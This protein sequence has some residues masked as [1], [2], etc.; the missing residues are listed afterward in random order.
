M[1]V[2]TLEKNLTR[3]HQEW[4]SRPDDE[5]YLS[6]DDLY[7]AVCGRANESR[8][9]TVPNR[10]LVVRGSEAAG[11][12]L[13]LEQ[14]DVGI[15]DPTHWSLGQL[16]TLSHTPAKWVREIAGAP[17]GPAFAAHALN[18]GLRHLASPEKV[19]LM[20]RV[21]ETGGQSLRCLV[22]PDYGRIYDY[23]VV[24]AVREMNRD[25]RWRVPAA[26]YSAS[27][28]L[29]A[30]TLY[31]SDR[32]VFIF[33][34]DDRN[35]I[36]FE[37]DGVKRN[38]FRGFMVWNSEVGSHRF[39]LMTFLYNFVCD[40]RIVWGAREVKEIAIRHTR[41]APERFSREALPRLY[42]YAESSVQNVEEQ[43]ARAARKTVTAKDEDVLSWL[44]S[45]DF[46]KKEGESIIE[47]ARSEEGGA[48]TV[49]QLV[50]GGTALARK[51]PHADERVTFERRVSRLLTAAA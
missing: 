21:G 9:L 17:A 48:R 15:L 16:A 26:S 35:P 6:L 36:S 47:M 49:W 22:G 42:A 34:V 2:A 27:N 39:G 38:L 19:Q 37:A 45:H 1:S 11:G 5:R 10:S 23:E 25:N 30:T 24:K 7:E 3:A 13:T 43:L 28:P 32:D 8:V 51:I 50:Q 31:A 20:S 41:N 33:L 46:T 40:N 4:I 14:E 18:L 29:R 44:R 12:A